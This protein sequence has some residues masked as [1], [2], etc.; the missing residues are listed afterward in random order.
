MI[1]ES[2]T[3]Q[4]FTIFHCHTEDI[5]T[6]RAGRQAWLDVVLS[7][8]KIQ[9]VQWP[10]DPSTM[11]DYRRIIDAGKFVL[12]WVEH[13]RIPEMIRAL[14]PKYM[15]RVWIVTTASDPEEA[16]A[17]IRALNKQHP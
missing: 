4:D 7:I 16:K 10:Y 11:E 6:N 1:K 14:G 3:T 8:P 2:E 9:G 12:S 17:V 13:A 5:A 15:K